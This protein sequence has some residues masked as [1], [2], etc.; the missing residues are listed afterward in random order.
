MTTLMLDGINSDAVTMSSQHVP[1]VAGYIDGD[2]AWTQEEWDL[3]PGIAHVTITVKGGSAK[4]DVC[5]CEKGDLTPA[6]A[7]DWVKARKAEG[8]DR[9]TIYTALSNVPAVREATGSYVAG[10]DYDIWVADWTGAAHPVA[11]PGLPAANAAAV[12]YLN[13]AHWDESCVN[14]PGWPHRTAAVIKPPASSGEV[15]LWPA[16][17]ELHQGSRGSD[18]KALQYG[19]RDSGL[20]LSAEL[21]QVDGVFGPKTFA[22]LQ[23]AQRDMGIKDDGVAGPVTRAA[24][25]ARGYLT[26]AGEG[27]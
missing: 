19:L 12:Q 25:I 3:F 6:Q 18:V 5:D 1:Y 15:D 17:V 7:A 4:A 27:R 16:G 22:A 24:M 14:D 13:A 2:Y 10:K 23:A 8:Y 11:L 26:S 20:R 21:G 9:P